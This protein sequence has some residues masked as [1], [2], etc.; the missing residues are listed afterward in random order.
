MKCEL[1]MP[2]DELCSP[3]AALRIP[4][5]DFGIVKGWKG[6]INFLRRFIIP[7]G[8]FSFLKIIIIEEAEWIRRKE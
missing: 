4:R 7:R 2:V 3:Y 1:R 5:V 8:K 6:L